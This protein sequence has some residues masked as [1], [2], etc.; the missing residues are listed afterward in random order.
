MQKLLSLLLFSLLV[1]P[2]VVQSAE[3]MIAPL[4]EELWTLE[5]KAI[6]YALNYVDEDD[7]AP[8]NIISTIAHDSALLRVF[9]PMATKLGSTT[10]IDARELELLALRTAWRAKSVYEWEHH[11]SSGLKAGLSQSEMAL[12]RTEKPDAGFGIRDLLLIQTADEL[13]AGTQLGADTMTRLMKEYTEAE[14]IEIIFI[15]NQYNGL[16]KFANSVGVQLE[17]GYVRQ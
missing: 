13:V 1:M 16:S 10:K 4:N 17:P 12:L 3:P 11:Y 8:I 2:G 9:L 6:F 5:H 7:K 15:V 14:V